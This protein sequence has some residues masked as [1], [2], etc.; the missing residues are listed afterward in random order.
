MEV[1]RTSI[2]DSFYANHAEHGRFFHLLESGVLAVWMPE[3]ISSL[4]IISSFSCIIM[5]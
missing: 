4:C 1:R 2:G 5:I 3:M